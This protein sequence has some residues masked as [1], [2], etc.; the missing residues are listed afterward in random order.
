MKNRYRLR[1]TLAAVTAAV[2]ASSLCLN[3]SY[4][5]SETVSAAADADD[6]DI[7]SATFVQNELS[8]ALTQS[9]VDSL[10]ER[11]D[12]REQGL[13]SAVKNQGNFGTCWTF[14]ACGAL[15][16]CLM[17]YFPFIDLSELHLAYFSFFGD[18]TPESPEKDPDRFISGG[19][20]SYAAA[21]FARW[22]G[23]VHEKLLPYSTAEEDI[24]TELQNRSEY[25]ITDVNILNQY[26][27]PDVDSGEVIRFSD[28]EI[29]QM[30]LDENAV[31]VN[32]R[33]DNTCNEETF[34][35]YDSTGGKTNHGVLI[36]GWDDS[37]SRDNFLDTPPGDGAWIVKNSWGDQWG[38]DGY[39]YVSYYDRSLAD[40]C[41][42]K[43]EPR[44]FCDKNY[45]HDTLFYTAAVSPDRADRNTGYMANIFESERDEFITGTGFYT[46]DNNAEYEITVYTDLKNSSDPTSGTPSETIY[47]T[48]KY[49][50]WHTVN[51]LLSSVRPEVHKGELF[52]VVVRLTNPGYSSPIPAEAAVVLMEN[53]FAN[54][55]S[56]IS[57][58]EIEA[59]SEAGQSFISSNGTRWTDTKG[60]EI[61]EV[62]D[63]IKIP[64]ANIMYYVG[65][66]CLKAYTSEK[67]SSPPKLPESYYTEKYGVRPVLTSVTLNGKPL[68][69]C[70]GD[71]NPVTEISAEV[72]G[73]EETAVIFPVGGG[74]ISVNG[75][76]TVSGHRSEEIPL[77][78]GENIIKV[79]TEN[80]GGKTEYTL[81]VTRNRA[82]VDYSDEKIVFDEENVS[83]TD[84]EG[85]RFTDGEII[86]D[87]LGKTV[88]VTEPDREYELDI[89]PRKDLDAVLGENALS[90]S[91]ESVS[92]L[93]SFR[94]DV[95]YST[96]PDMSEPQ[97]I[98]NRM[99]NLLTETAFRVYPGYDTDLYFQIAATDEAPAST[100][101]HVSVPERPVISEDDIRI[102]VIDDTSF[103]FTVDTE[104]RKTEYKTEIKYTTDRPDSSKMY[105]SEN[106][107]EETTVV[108]G[109]VPG[110]TY[111]LYIREF[112]DQ[113]RFSTEITEFNVTL[114]DSSG[115]QRVCSFN[116][117]KERIIFD[118][119]R[120]TAAACDGRKLKCYDLISEYTGTEVV[121]EDANGN[122]T[123]VSIPERRKS[124]GTEIDYKAGRLTGEFGDEILF[125]CNRKNAF[126]TTPG[127]SSSLADKNGIITLDR[128]YS[129]YYSSGDRINF[130][131]GATD[132]EF[133]SEMSTIIIPS[134]ESVSRK[135]LK[136]TDYTE[137]EIF[138]EPHSGLEY[139]YREY[140]HEDFTW[141][142]SP[143]ITGLRAG[144]QYILAVRYKA[145]ENQPCSRSTYSVISTLKEKYTAGDLNDDGNVN[146]ADAVIF[147]KIL[148]ADV[149]PD[150]FQRRGADMNTDG[151]VNTID[152]RQLINLIS[153]R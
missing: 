41:C 72:S 57:E 111:S 92:G 51:F 93:F 62:Y 116:F 45:Q 106:V 56:N 75:K 101:F 145:T 87:W 144:R 127:K 25:F 29:K 150:A 140:F 142:D 152:F 63:N 108:E 109:L 79:K 86:S 113:N 149:K 89:A 136:I 9:E 91:S 30:L 135:L 97:D 68:N 10:P 12:L 124:P 85:H 153:N 3:C 125:N 50:G 32:I 40:A 18:N 15:E 82:A 121:F 83:V 20:I 64:D 88:Y 100:V 24:D 58:E 133:A 117:E 59:N 143:A 138:L 46:T 84:G 47:G 128:L 39:F 129:S 147:R 60:L 48:E 103:S 31:A 80:A 7:F 22:T 53:R 122:S 99:M 126:D 115:V 77:E 90:Y 8:P 49:A 66:V 123:T 54:N 21:S 81:K 76:D 33:Y 5:Q 38:L 36:V 151:S 55:V 43:A 69:I 137:H 14:A 104:G 148:L 95:F 11:F 19:H 73:T 17:R 131:Y 78:F 141:Q 52:S 34:A 35:Q 65:N 130:F 71:E 94:G 44:Y 13:V 16:T 28:E 70:D 105:Y 2:M 96:S 120:Y 114:P 118:E 132:E 139:G 146:A 26:T 27:M 42:L 107:K 102:E 23:P 74:N 37:Y 98:H 119:D 134:P 6:A 112:S 61:E 4:L 110:N 67:L 1:K